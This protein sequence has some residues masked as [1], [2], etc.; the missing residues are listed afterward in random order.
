MANNEKAKLYKQIVSQTDEY[1][2]LQ[3]MQTLG[4]WPEAEGIPEDPDE[5]IDERRDIDQK[6]SELRKQA[7]V[8]KN[9]EKALQQER[10]RRWQE[11][12][13]R[14]AAAKAEREEN[15]QKRR[16]QWAAE[17]AATIVHAGEDVSAGLQ[18]TQS[19]QAKLLRQ[20]LPILHSGAEVA[21][22]IGLSLAR[23]RWLTYHRKGAPLVHYHR[24]EIPK[25]TGGTRLISAPKPDLARAQRWVLENVLNRLEIEAPAHGFVTGRS[26]VSGATPHS[27]RA[28]VINI[29][30][31]DFFPTITF[32]RVKGLFAKMGYSEHVATVF[33]LLCTEPPRVEVKLDGTSFYIA[34]GDRRLPQGACTSPAI[35]NLICRRL[36]RRL[37]GLCQKIGYTYTRY[38]DDLSFSGDDSA[39]VGS[40]LRCVRQILD[41]EGFEE[42]PTKTKVMRKSRRQEVTGLTVNDRPTLSRKERRRLRAILHNAAKH[43]LHSQNRHGHPAF[44]DHL[45]GKVAFA[46]MVDPK[47]AQKWWDAL[48]HALHHQ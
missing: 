5:E 42:H 26:I 34:L 10:I 22:A 27:G 48:D 7:T 32:R 9:P 43:G 47:N 18:D 8:V 45:R 30:L 40:L 29:D 21:E 11:S 14:R 20:S 41:D 6:I 2:M 44:A 25:K 35:T 17:K 13:L 36:D 31:K 39:K 46:A 33:A 15:L 24:F 23:L 4:F 28:V 38:A 1:T 3:R 16:E 12:K 37:A 19:D